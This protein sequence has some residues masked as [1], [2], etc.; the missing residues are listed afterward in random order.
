MIT[1]DLLLGGAFVYFTTPGEP[2]FMVTCN[3]YF[4]YGLHPFK[5]WNFLHGLIF[6]FLLM[7]H[8]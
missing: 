4:V 3:L 8:A 5:K 2:G 1:N 7:L 6:E